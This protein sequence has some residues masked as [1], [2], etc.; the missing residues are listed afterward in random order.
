MRC[1]FY[2]LPFVGV[3]CLLLVCCLLS[4]VGKSLLLVVCGLLCVLVVVCCLMHVI[5][6]SLC[7]VRCLLVVD[8]CCLLECGYCYKLFGTGCVLLVVW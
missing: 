7:V 5:R 6:S 3:C 8:C 4:I 2:C 1:L